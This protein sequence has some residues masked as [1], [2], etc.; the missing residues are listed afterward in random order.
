MLSLPNELEQ[1][2]SSST[3]LP[4]VPTPEMELLGFKHSQKFYLDKNRVIIYDEEHNS[5]E[6]T[7]L[8]DAL[9]REDEVPLIKLYKKFDIPPEK[10]YLKVPCIARNN[11]RPFNC[12]NSMR[13]EIRNLTEIK[14]PNIPKLYGYRELDGYILG[15]YI[16]KYDITLEDLLKS[17]VNFDRHK[18]FAKLCEIVKSIHK[19]GYVHAD[20]NRFNV[21]VKKENLDEPFLIDFDSAEKIGAEIKYL[22]KILTIIY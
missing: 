2:S 6:A 3:S 10:M 8:G 19:Q 15:L 11:W 4:S 13:R 5:V 22:M 21:M 12:K 14:H 7:S 1:Q 16:D 18:F 20:I 9:L 17:K